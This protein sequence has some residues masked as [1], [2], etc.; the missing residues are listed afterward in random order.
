ME[1][2]RAARAESR[3]IAAAAAEWSPSSRAFLSRPGNVVSWSLG[4][5]AANSTCS[6]G[7]A[8]SLTAKPGADATSLASG[9]G[10]TTVGVTNTATGSTSVTNY[11]GHNGGLT[12]TWDGGGPGATMTVAGVVTNPGPDN[13]ADFSNGSIPGQGGAGDH[14]PATNAGGG[15]NILIIART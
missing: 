15:A 14:G 6:F 12:D 10:A 13:T 4:G 5:A 7:A 8:L 3:Q 1:P 9:A 11:A 2:T